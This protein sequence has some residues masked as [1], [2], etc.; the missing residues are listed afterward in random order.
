MASLVSSR[1]PTLGTQINTIVLSGVLIYELFGP[2]I[3]KLA[4]TRAGEITPAKG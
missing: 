2:I 1:F 4:L 3:T